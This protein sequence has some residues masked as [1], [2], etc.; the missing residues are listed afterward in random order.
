[1]EGPKAIGYHGIE[2]NSRVFPA[3]QRTNHTSITVACLSQ[4]SSDEMQLLADV[5][6]LVGTGPDKASAP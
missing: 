6:T 2:I 5:R 1:M 4:N 3:V